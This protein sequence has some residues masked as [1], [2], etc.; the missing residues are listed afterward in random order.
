MPPYLPT[1]TKRQTFVT[2]FQA[3]KPQPL[4]YVRTLLQTILFGDMRILG[5]YSIRQILDDDLSILVL[6]VSPLLDRAND[7]VEVIHDPRFVFA[8]EMENFRLR[9]RQP[10][11]DVLRTACQNRCR[12]RR[13]LYHVVRAWDSLQVEAEEIDFSIQQVSG[14]QPVEGQF[15]LPLASWTY[16]YKLKMM[17]AIVQLGFELELYQTDELHSMYWYLENLSEHRTSHEQRIKKYLSKHL[18]FLASQPSPPP[19]SEAQME[20]AMNHIR[21]SI[22][23]STA[24]SEFSQALSYIYTV[25]HQLGLIVPPPRPYSDDEMRYQLRM[26]PFAS[27]GLPEMPTLRDIEALQRSGLSVLVQLE[28]ADDAIRKATR[29]FKNMSKL[30]PKEA[31]AVGCHD[32]W[33][34]EIKSC[35]QATIAA[36]ITVR[37]LEDAIQAAPAKDKVK[38]FLRLEVPLPSASYHHWWI[39]PKVSKIE[40]K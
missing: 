40:Q 23:H 9:A 21:L 37:G 31:F 17:E 25:L 38:E 34:A 20:R 36:G 3:K 32:R 39:V 24:T 15:S 16:L 33:L 22:L 11:L 26:K 29:L 18:H 13:S 14:E 8:T 19:G 10:F 35:C 2:T 27:I 4:V 1:P 5:A 28:M 30:T 6:P 7:D 12:V